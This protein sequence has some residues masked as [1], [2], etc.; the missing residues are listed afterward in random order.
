[1]AAANALAREG[2]VEGD[3]ASPLVKLF[4]LWTRNLAPGLDVQHM[5]HRSAQCFLLLHDTYY[6]VKASA[7]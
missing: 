2:R 4:T 6:E 1:M 5:G 7:G 3:L